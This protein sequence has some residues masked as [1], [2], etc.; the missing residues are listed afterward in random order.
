MNTKHVPIAKQYERKEECIRILHLSPK[1][2]V[3]EFTKVIF[4][5][6]RS[7]R[8]MAKSLIIHYIKTSMKSN[9]NHNNCQPKKYPTQFIR[10]SIVQLWNGHPIIK[11]DCIRSNN[12]ITYPSFYLF[13]EDSKNGYQWNIR[14]H[15]FTLPNISVKLS[16]L[17]F[18]EQQ[19]IQYFL[20]KRLFLID[21][22]G[23]IGQDA[24]YSHFVHNE[25]IKEIL[26]R[27]SSALRLNI[28]QA[29][30]KEIIRISHNDYRN[31]VKECIQQSIRFC[32]GKVVD[33]SSLLLRSSSNSNKA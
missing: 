6:K 10:S 31:D 25:L 17:G 2:C 32:I 28:I 29:F 1:E 9:N 23:Y 5:S 27:N 30:I 26:A 22:K 21:H 24:K 19:Y 3:E 20:A 18:K 15:L 14:L 11:I 12:S 13:D 33:P 16:E 7:L 4:S 8:L